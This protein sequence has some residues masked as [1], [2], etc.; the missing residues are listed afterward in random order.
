MAS[1]R[2]KNAPRVDDTTEEPTRPL[3]FNE[4]NERGGR[5]GDLLSPARASEEF[6]AERARLAGMTGGENPAGEVT[7]DDLAPETLLD[8]SRSHSP[9]ARAGRDANDARLRVVDE[10]EIGAGLG[11]D[12]VELARGGESDAE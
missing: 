7:A 1:K 4:G 12:E 9:A 2:P 6:P 8:E 5:T 10:S 3:D 11:K